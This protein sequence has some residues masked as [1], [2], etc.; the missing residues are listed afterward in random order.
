MLFT[1]FFPKEFE[2]TCRKTS[3]ESNFFNKL[4]NF[5]EN[6]EHFKGRKHT[7]LFNKNPYTSAKIK[8]ELYYAEQFSSTFLIAKNVL[9]TTKKKL[10]HHGKVY[11]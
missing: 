5:I 11:H 6:K 4:W 3:L 9:K 2:I 8:I 7:Y 1:A 10:N